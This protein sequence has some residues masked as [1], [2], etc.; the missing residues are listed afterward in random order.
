MNNPP[1]RR[2]VPGVTDLDLWISSAGAG[3]VVELSGSL[4]ATTAADLESRL[5]AELHAPRQ[6]L[7]DLG[8]VIY[9][10]SMGLSVILKTAIKLKNSGSECRIYDPQRSVRRVLEIAKW[11]HLIIDPARV[12]ADDPFHG[13]ISSEEPAR[14]ARR[15][16]GSGA[17]APPRLYPD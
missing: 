8:Q 13:Y 2:S 1:K 6:V 4:D 3:A 16:S 15:A 12:A 9:L 11:S 17:A 10:S 14:S 7:L 5:M